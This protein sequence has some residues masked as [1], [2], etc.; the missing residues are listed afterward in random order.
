MLGGVVRGREGRRG[1]MKEKDHRLLD[2]LKPSRSSSLYDASGWTISLLKRTRRSSGFS[3]EDLRPSL[4][5]FPI[6][7]PLFSSFSLFLSLSRTLGLWLVRGW[8]RSRRRRTGSA[9]E[10]GLEGLS[11]GRSTTTKCFLAS[12]TALGCSTSLQRRRRGREETK[13]L[14]AMRLCKIRL[15]PD[16]FLQT[17]K[18]PQIIPL[19]P[20]ASAVPLRF[21]I[22]GTGLCAPPPTTASLALR[23]PRGGA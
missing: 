19:P 21:N 10:E 18:Q 7:S 11:E 17:G 22:P 6:I 23:S 2:F 16:F 13:W 20:P 5:L 4:R 1:R 9:E 3:P 15:L 12:S 14:N 8:W